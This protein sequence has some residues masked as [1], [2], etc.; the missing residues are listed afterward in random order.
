MQ[1]SVATSSSNGI[2]A[3]PISTIDFWLLPLSRAVRRKLASIDESRKDHPAQKIALASVLLDHACDR[4]RGIY[5]PLTSHPFLKAKLTE[6]FASVPTSIRAD[7]GTTLCFFGNPLLLPENFDDQLFDCGKAIKPSLR[8]TNAGL[9][10]VTVEY[11]CQSRDQFEQMFE[12]LGST[13]KFKEVDKKLKAYRDY[14]GFC[15]VL[16]GNRSLHFHF[17]FDTRH[18]TKA[19]YDQTWEHR[20]RSHHAQ[21]AVMSNVHQV[22][23][24]TV[25]EV[26]NESLAPPIAADR[27]MEAYTQFKRMP[28]GIRRLEERS[29]I[30]DLPAGSLV[31]QLVLA[32]RIRADRSARG[33]D[34]FIVGAE[35]SVPNYL[36]ARKH[37]DSAA[38]AKLGPGEVSAGQNM[39]SELASMCQSEWGSEFPKPVRRRSEVNGSSISRTIPATGTHLQSLKATSPRCLFSARAL[40]SVRSHFPANCQPTKLVII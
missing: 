19:P 18:L 39:V 4:D 21:A 34:K 32:E 3:I 35:F 9:V 1:A 20:W 13:G 8:A 40:P 25:A 28:W 22:Y 5:V 31:P 10:F 26:M 11:D 16:S 29:D 17:P 7:V 2:M 27:S 33:S 12:W 15:V 30:L 6:D 14:S 24:N 38:S 36:R 37:Y 23:W